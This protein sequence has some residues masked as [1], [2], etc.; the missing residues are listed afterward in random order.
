[1]AITV[2][3]PTFEYI[4]PVKVSSLKAIHFTFAP[5]TICSAES[6]DRTDG[7]TCLA[8]RYYN[9]TANTTT[10]VMK[11][12]WF[13]NNLN[14]YQFFIDGKPTPASPSQVRLGHSENLA[15]L[16]RALHF[17]HKSGDGQYL[18]LLQDVGNYTD[19][20]FVLGQEFESFSQKSRV[21]ESGMNTL[22]S[23]ITLRLYFTNGTTCYQWEC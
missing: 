13:W 9:A 8:G 1:M 15:E 20:N 12:S 2:N 11:T 16:S 17:G 4:I 18:S 22:N 3:N 10:R 14:S 19:Q 5:Q 21:I 23:L 7:F 6:F